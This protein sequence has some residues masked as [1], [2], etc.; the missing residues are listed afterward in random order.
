MKKLV[1]LV[2]CLV[3]LAGCAAGG[4]TAAPTLPQ[5]GP[6]FVPPGTTAG[7]PP[8]TQ[9]QPT[10][11][12]DAT[13][14]TGTAGTAFTPY[15]ENIKNPD[16]PVYKGPGYDT[17]KVGTVEKATAYTIVAEERDAEGNLWGKLKSGAGWIDLDDARKGG[18]ATVP[19][20]EPKPDP[21]PK[22]D[23]EPK[24]TAAK[25]LPE[26]VKGMW[27][28]QFD[29]SGVYQNGGTQRSQADFE[30]RM[31]KLLDNVKALGFNTVFLQVRPN[32]DSMYPSKYYPMSS[33]VTGALGANAKY[34]PVEITVALAHQRGLFIHAWI[35]P[36]RAMKEADIQ[37]VGRDYPIRRWYDDA[38][39]RGKYLV[40][41]N[42]QLYLNPAYPEVA[43][44][45]VS[46]AA[47]VM[48]SYDFDGLH[49][50]D[51]FY[52]TTDAS[53]DKAAYDSYK[54]GGGKLSLAD[55]RRDTLNKLVARLYKTAG[56]K[57]FGISPAGNMSSVYNSMYADVYT[58][59][60][61]PGYV[62]YICPQVYFGMEHGSYDFVSVCRTWE[63][64]IKTD[65][66][67]LIVGMSFG[68]ALSQ[69]D[70]WAGDGKDEWKNHK[71]VLKRSLEST[72]NLQTCMG[73]C[74]FCYQYFYD[75]VSGAEVAGT[76]QERANFLPVL[77]TIT[78]N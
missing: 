26:N 73:V 44:L 23:P 21:D 45:I 9:P 71:D 65:S 40:A 55:F 34:D 66:V 56:D 2:L 24:P 68:K 62:D 46:G 14:P 3:C 72:E 57:A 1:S 61:E 48:A 50:D 60:S 8:T 77:K 38:S 36:M 42:G 64:I 12:G 4:G 52:P 43:D 63:G 28:S 29:L 22:P 37:K 30:A 35:N 76:A 67:R 69:E 53:F 7:T 41:V 47:E 78:W 31:G 49:M 16:Q 18:P 54:S 20:P 17:G 70:Q 32:A 75:P 39:L 10:G 6:V 51:Y 27:L 15:I 33:Y 13:E 74:V 11:T 25:G 58:W 5:S 19:D 59:C